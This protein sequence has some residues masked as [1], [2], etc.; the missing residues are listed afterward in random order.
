MTEE[1]FDIKKWKKDRDKLLTAWCIGIILFIL[2]AVF[3][4]L[5]GRQRIERI[6]K[7]QEKI[8]EMLEE[9]K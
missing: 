8:M 4:I 7:N 6:E 5:S 3:I 1:K 9:K 2:G